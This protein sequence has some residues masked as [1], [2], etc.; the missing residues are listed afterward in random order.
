[1]ADNPTKEALYE[2]LDYLEQVETES[3]ALMAFFRANGTI[4]DEKFAPYL[5]QAENATDVKSR[6]IRARFEHLFTSEETVVTATEANPGTPNQRPPQE[7]STTK[8]VS[9]HQEPSAREKE[10]QEQKPERKN[11]AA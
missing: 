6:A 3:G 4:T 9:S 2:L 10:D 8:E 7:S 5:E 11:E 1:V